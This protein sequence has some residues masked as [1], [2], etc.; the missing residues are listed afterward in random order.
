MVACVC[1]GKVNTPAFQKCKA[2]IAASS[3]ASVATI[4]PLFATDYE[5]ELSSLKT[6]IGGR[7][8]DHTADVAAYTEDGEWIGDDAELL[9]WLK[10]KGCVPPPLRSTAMA[11]RPGRASP[12]RSLSR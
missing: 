3:A 10:R 7:A 2:L 1:I 6:S 8:Y 4:K 5:K 12:R 11:R 9:L